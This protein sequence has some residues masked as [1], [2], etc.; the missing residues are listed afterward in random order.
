[1]VHGGIRDVKTACVYVPR[2]C[3]CS[4]INTHIARHKQC[5]LSTPNGSGCPC[6]GCGT[7]PNNDAGSPMTLR[8]SCDVTPPESPLCGAQTTSAT[9]LPACR[10]W[11]RVSLQSP[12]RPPTGIITA[13]DMHWHEWRRRSRV[14]A[15]TLILGRVAASANTPA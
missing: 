15:S 10:A 12:S 3:I 8:Q 5:K 6:R 4:K 13:H 1:M 7:A 11:G 14:I 2:Y 9:P